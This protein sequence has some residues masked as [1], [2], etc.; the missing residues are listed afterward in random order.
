MTLE[1]HFQNIQPAIIRHLQQAQQEILVAVAWFTDRELFEV[2]CKKAQAGVKVAVALLDDKI[3][4]GQ[5]SLNFHRLVNLR[6][7]VVFLPSGS[8]GEAMMHHKFCVLDGATV[9]TGS[10]NWSN[11]A[12]RND[13]NITV[14]T[15]QPDY[16]ARYRQ[17]FLD[18][19]ARSG[20]ADSAV[21]APVDTEAVRR[22]LEMVRNLILL[23]EQDDLPPHLGKLRPVA[24]ALRLQPI[25]QALESGAYKLALESI[26]AYLRRSSALVLRDDAEVPRLQ[27]LLQTLELRLESLTDEKSDLERELAIFNRCH[28]DALGELLIRVLA[29]RKEMAR[30]EAEASRRRAEESRA[31]A[32]EDESDEEAAQMAEEDVRQ[33]EQAREQAEQCEQEYEEFNQEYEREQA[34]KPPDALD[35]QDVV[36][37]KKTYRKCASLCHPDKFPEEHQE[38]AAEVF[39]ALK[40][41]YDANDLPKVREIFTTLQAGGLPRAP[42]SSTLSRADALRAAIAELQHRIAA[43]LRGLQVLV[44]SDGVKLLRSAGRSQHDWPA[45]FERQQRLLSAELER[46]QQA[47]AALG[48]SESDIGWIGD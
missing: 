20:Q 45:F 32:V 6:G 10:Y 5:G 29:A 44:S 48:A 38:A 39:V 46:L 13:E 2:L 12:R 24:E 41:A 18:L 26:E 35:E 7:K 30:L 37:L 40:A 14:V 28:S 8:D 36:E 9:I 21:Q 1:A 22:R 42:R 17:A 15:E 43:T 3:N 23:G 11:K 34:R 4:R 31:A 33:A 16:T 19:L 25:I 27:L 47:V